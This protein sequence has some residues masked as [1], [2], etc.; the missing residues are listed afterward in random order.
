MTATSAGSQRDPEEFLAKFLEGLQDKRVEED[1]NYAL[2]GR[3]SNNIATKA[4][5]GVLRV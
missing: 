1:G 4:A 3:M 2:Y 5:T